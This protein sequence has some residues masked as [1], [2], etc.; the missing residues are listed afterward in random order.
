M[1]MMLTS[2]DRTAELQRATQRCFGYQWTHFADM[3]DANREHF[4]TYIFPVELSFFRKV[5]I[6]WCV[7]VREACLLCA[8]IWRE[9][10]RGGIQRCRLIGRKTP[11][12]QGRGLPIESCISNDTQTTYLPVQPERVEG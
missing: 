11:Q 1:T 3:V 12:R 7:R 4:L 8:R 9:D 2:K 10:G 5:W 6:G